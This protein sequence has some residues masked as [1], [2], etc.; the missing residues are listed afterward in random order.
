MSTSTMDAPAPWQIWIDRGGTFTDLVACTPDGDL[1]SH[2]LLSEN[3]EQYE[4]AALQG[5]RDLVGI[6]KGQPIPTG[7]PGE[8]NPIQGQSV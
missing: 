8:D 5:I 1:V 7:T 3:P 6:K 4:D 2:K